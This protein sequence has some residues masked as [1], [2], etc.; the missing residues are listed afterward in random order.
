M[1]V[2]PSKKDAGA[3]AALSRK[4]WKTTGK[5]QSQALRRNCKKLSLGYRADGER[6]S[7]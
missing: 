2:R 1:K 6:L 5:L 7:K 4:H 3:T